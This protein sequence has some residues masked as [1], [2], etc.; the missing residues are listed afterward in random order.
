[1]YEHLIVVF[2]RQDEL[3]EHNM[4]MYQYVSKNQPDLETVLNKCQRRFIGFDNEGSV[5]SKDKDARSL[6]HMIETVVSEKG[7]IDTEIFREIEEQWMFTPE[8]DMEEMMDD[9]QI[10]Q[11]SA[12]EETQRKDPTEQKRSYFGNKFE[13]IRQQFEMATQK[14]TEMERKELPKDESTKQNTIQPKPRTNIKELA[15]IQ[16]ERNKQLQ[17]VGQMKGENGRENIR[18][19]F[20]AENGAGQIWERIRHVAKRV[21]EKLI[22]KSIDESFNV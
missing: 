14:E 6:I 4:T 7:F 9:L 2:T 3:K 8:S 20:V 21:W 5:I 16:M 1:M 15:D 17:H 18:Q 19:D 12:N 13:E 22:F 11:C 10:E